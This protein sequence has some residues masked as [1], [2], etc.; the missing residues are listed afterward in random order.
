MAFNLGDIFVTFKAKTD[1][2][3]NGVGKV[4]SLTKQ[5]EQSVN[6]TSFKAFSSQ[7]SGAFGGVANAIQGVITKAAIFATTSS[8]GIGAFVKS[9]ADLQQTSKSFEVL[10]GNVEIANKLFAQLARY[11]NTT[12]FEFPQ[13]AKAGQVLLGFGIK[14][15]DVYGKIQML[16]DI[17]A[18]T[19]A[20]F[21]SL[22]LVFGQ[23]NATG[24][25]MGQDSLQLINNKIPI[26][27]ILAK[28]MGLT[29]QEVREQMEAGKIGVDLF[30]EA[31]EETTKKGGFAFKGTDVL[32]QS[33]NGRLSTLKDTVLEFGR[34]LIGVKVDPKLGLTIKKGGIF[35][36]ISELVPKIGQAL[37]DI[38]PKIQAGFAYLVDHGNEI[39]MI[40]IAIGVAFVAAKVAAI[41]FAIVAAANPVTLIAA[42]IVVLIGVLTYLQQKF[43]FIGKT[44]DFLRPII[45]N[46][47][48][49]FTTAFLPSVMALATSLATYLFPALKQIWDS[50]MRLWNALSPG[51]MQVLKVVGAL[52]AFQLVG[53]IWIFINVL[54]IIVITISGVV[55]AISNLI[56]W[57]G[58]LISWFG[59]LYG[60]VRNAVAG[61]IGWF[62]RLPN[63]LGAIINKIEGL[64]KGLPGKIGRVAGGIYDAVTSPFRKAFNWITD[65]VDK[66]KAIISKLSPGNI[67]SSIGNRIKGL[68]PGFDTGI[69]NFGGGLAYVHGG[70]V[71]TN[72]PK[73]TNVIPKNQAGQA[74][75]GANRE[76]KIYGDINI[77]DKMDAD[78]FFKRIDRNSILES[79]GISPV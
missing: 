2:L 12:P 29:V 4:K 63:T 20:D 41:G 24:H 31:L 43:D 52:L 42:A 19:G 70:E 9:A 30:N 58:N 10:T 34:N 59:N 40:L 38:G 64:F 68:I 5:A 16:G 51:L 1:D 6:G 67:T 45:A 79:R 21:Q 33:L 66:V 71:L 48:S 50:V 25:L 23:V 36:R 44:M 32:A 62:D 11:A 72:L 57:I 7:A 47:I 22:A 15:G 14:S 13:I 37:V 76:V 46:L 61:M 73:G 74:L 75:A 49:I 27:S 3:Q 28:K 17:A 54:R 60:V 77:G 8:V 65:Q 55:S 39:K 35:D 56:K 53:M 26:T 18:A 69:T 78:Y